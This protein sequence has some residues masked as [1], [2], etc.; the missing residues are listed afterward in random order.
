MNASSTSWTLALDGTALPEKFLIGGKAWSIA[1]MR[2]LGLPVPP[3]FVI[4]TRACV[5]FLNSGR[6]PQG[7]EQQLADGVR[8]L[9]RQT[10]RTFGS[11]PQPLL[12]SVRSGAA[13]SMPGMMDTVLNLGINDLTERALAG[14]CADET[15][16]RDTHRRFIELYA[17]IVLKATVPELPPGLTPPE[18]RAAVASAAGA[19]IPEDVA[20][21]LR[22]AVH[23]VFDSWNSRRAKRYREHHGIAHD[24]GTAVTIQAMVFGNLDERSGT[25]V[26]FS[27][28]PLSG[29]PEPYGEYLPR[30]QGEDVVSG[31]FTPRPLA[32]MKLSVP[33]ALQELLAAAQTLE[34]ANGDMQDI[35]F[36]VERDRLYLLQTRAAKR[37]PLAAVCCAVD[38]A[39][40]G[41]IDEATALTR[42]TPEQLRTLLSPQLS[43]R[44]AA[45]ATV[46][47]S[48]E[49]ACPGVGIGVVV[50][51]SD[52]AERRAA[53]GEAIVLARPT[54][55]P[56]DLH[57]MIAACAVI[58]EQGGTTSHAAV[59]SR[60][61]GR[62]CIVGCGAGQLTALAG[63]V[64]T[65]DGH[66]GRVYADAL[67][68]AAPDEQA[69]ERLR[70]LAAWAQARTA[71]K[72]FRPAD[73][74]RDGVA[75]L[76]K[77]PGAE[78]PERIGQII[79]ALTGVRGARGGAIASV[80][81]VRAAID[82]GLEFIVAEPVLPALLTAAQ[83]CAPT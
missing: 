54:T 80:E 41:R 20:G 12:L 8:G 25:G 19:V 17:G 81:G 10:G 66:A 23:A 72:V 83:V 62:P 13:V 77:I 60:A 18:W 39:R 1:R 57:G 69:N 26:L 74:P 44:N 22:G 64:V 78:D 30:A 52:E 27:R 16:A 65:V 46:L 28:N 79:A 73:A 34:Q 24:A 32:E 42:V 7:L 37:A 71:L 48:G 14:E 59:V 43:A 31:K 33:Q 56:N 58:T 36:T 82:K 6:F 47:A 4:T 51:D 21:Q 9:E 49:S 76:D 63:R 50:V 67:E 11:G 3:A 35:E 5:E 2:S 45:A 68:V 40:E 75:D 55:S 38:M 15:F 53:N 29:A 70:A 61:L